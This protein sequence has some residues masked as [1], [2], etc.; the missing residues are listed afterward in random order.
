MDATTLIVAA[1][2][3]ALCIVPMVIA[4][5]KGKKNDGE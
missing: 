3:V 5:R 4:N 1:V 2:L